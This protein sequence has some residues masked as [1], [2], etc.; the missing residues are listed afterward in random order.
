M[1]LVIRVIVVLAFIWVGM[2]LSDYCVL[3]GSTENAA[4]PGLQCKYLG[5]RSVSTAQ[6][7]HSD[8]GIIGTSNCPV[9]RKN[10]KV[11]NHG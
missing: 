2:L 4:G 8:N 7:V 9:L 6:Y 5:A 1:R 3:T 10:K 11:I